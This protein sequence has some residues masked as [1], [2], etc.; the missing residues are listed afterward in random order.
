MQGEVKQEHQ[1]GLVGPD[2]GE[3]NYSGIGELYTSIAMSNTIR[4]CCQ[5]CGMIVARL[6]ARDR[7]VYYHNLTILAPHWIPPHIEIPGHMDTQ[8]A[9]GFSFECCP[10]QHELRARQEQRRT[11]M[12]Y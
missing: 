10:V 9:L 2:G 5:A 4:V 12:I 3:Y 8:T 11:P 1:N 6:E 7:E